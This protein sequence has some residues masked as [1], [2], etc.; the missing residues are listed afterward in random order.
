[1]MSGTSAVAKNAKVRGFPSPSFDGFAFTDKVLIEAWLR[2]Y[3][4]NAQ[5]CHWD[6]NLLKQCRNGSLDR[7]D[8]DACLIG[9]ASAYWKRPKKDRRHR[10]IGIDPV[11]W[12]RR[13]GQ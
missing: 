11:Q 9:C 2:R 7:A 6:D 12:L 10:Q 5:F 13:N 4:K 8:P 3:Q 1:M